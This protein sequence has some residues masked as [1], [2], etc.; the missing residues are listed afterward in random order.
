M[1][2]GE[3]ARDDVARPGLTFM[4]ITIEFRERNAQRIKPLGSFITLWDIGEGKMIRIQEF[5][6]K[7]PKR[8]TT[9]RDHVTVVDLGRLNRST[10]V[11]L[12]SYLLHLSKRL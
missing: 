7:Q 3:G 4:R 6:L 2:L 9:L 11:M 8:P 12:R 1:E 10:S 5:V